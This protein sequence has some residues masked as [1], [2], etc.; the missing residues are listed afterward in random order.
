MALRQELRA[1]KRTTKRP[2]LRTRDRLFWIVLANAWQ[3]WRMA[4][5]LV[6]LETVLRWHRDWLRRRWT[7]RS[8][9]RP[10]GRPPIDQQIRAL[11][12]TWRPQIRCGEQRGFTVSSAGYTQPSG[13]TRFAN[14]QSL[15]TSRHWPGALLLAAIATPHR[16]EGWREGPLL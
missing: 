11:V 14:R 7:R 4:L 9:R 5:V 15:A 6:E 3:H 13:L 12:E 1:F 8:K 2:R 16:V 10:D